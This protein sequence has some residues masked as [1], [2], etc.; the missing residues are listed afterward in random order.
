MPNS[1]ADLPAPPT[2]RAT[3]RQ[4][5]VRAGGLLAPVRHPLATLVAAAATVVLVTLAGFLLRAHPVDA[6]L[7]VALNGP[8]T[9]VVAH[10]TALAYAAFSPVP[11]TI[12]TLLLAAAVAIVTRRIRLAAAI[13]GVVALT[14]LPS[15]LVKLLVDRPRPDAGLLAHAVSPTPADASYPSGHV[16]FATTLALTVI[17][18][19]WHTRAR[20]VALIG[21]FLVV[22]TMVATVTILAVHYPTDALASLVWT[23]GVFPAARFVWVGLVLPLFP[24]RADA[25]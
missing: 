23:L 16:V 4:S 1:P 17:L 15:A 6:G 20:I 18:L 9:G 25:G 10:V 2:R 24:A 12:L 7:S 3:R 21:G 22:A 8:R 19:A 14:W 5:E 11:A 13:P